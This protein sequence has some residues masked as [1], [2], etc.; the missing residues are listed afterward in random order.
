MEKLERLEISSNRISDTEG[1]YAKLSNLQRLQSL[2]LSYNE[3]DAFDVGDFDALE[4]L[5]LRNNNLTEWPDGVATANR[6]RSLNLSGNDITSVPEDVLD[7]SHEVLLSGT[8]MSDNYNLSLESLE[9]LRTYR[10]EGLHDTVLGFSRSDLDD[11]IDDA[12]GFDEAS[13]DSIETDEELSETEPDSA[14]REPWLANAPAEELAGKKETWNQLAAEPDNAAFFHLIARLQDTQEFRVAKADLTRRVWTVMDAAA[15]NSELR[16]V[17]F[18]GSATHG[19]C[20][21][22]RIL[23]FS[24]LE[25]KVFTHN[26][27]LDI[28]VGRL[29][30]KGDALLRLSRQLFRLDKVDELATKTAARAGHD[31][32][33]VR[34]GYRIGLTDGWPDGLSLPG[35]PR[36]M[37]YASGV[38]PGQ[39]AQARIE[40]GNAERSDGFFEDLIQRDY[41][42]SYLKEKYPEDFRAL[43]EMDVQEMDTDEVGNADDPAFL[44]VLFDQAAARNAKMIELS[45]KEVAEL[46]SNG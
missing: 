43:D 6:L 37:T 18:A 42:V 11:L 27:L 29:S 4:T 8:D 13:I 45:R 1:L 21:D 23:T 3:L 7:G 22:G 10:E 33:E 9:R 5:D 35:Q 28:P 34:L 46:A 39:L 41:W 32:A 26:A 17:L 40:I 38:T 36:H 31:E 25:S 14:Q 2:D 19:T 30:E 12:H 24:G 44:S 15:S 16:E 20:V